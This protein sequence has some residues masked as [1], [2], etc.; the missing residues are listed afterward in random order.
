MKKWLLMLCLGCFATVFAADLDRSQPPTPGP[1]PK[2]ELG[3]YQSFTLDNGLKVFVVE[4]HKMPRVALSLTLDVDPVKEHDAVGYIS[5]TGQM[6]RSG[7]ESRDKDT[8]DREIDYIAANLF[9]TAGGVYAASLRR[10]CE[11]LFELTADVLINPSFPEEELAKLKKQAL[12]NLA[13]VANDPGQL[14]SRVRDALLFG[15]N[16][17]YGEIQEESDIE[18]IDRSKLADYHGKFF[19]PNVAYMAVVGDITFD[20]AK[21]MVT[22][23]FGGWEKKEVPSLKYPKPSL[24]ETRFVALV[25]RPES[26]Q[27]SLEVTNVVFRKLG[28]EDY[29]AATLAQT[30]LGGTS[31]YR[32]YNNLREDKGYTY[33][34]Y[35]ALGSDDV[36]SRFSTTAEVRNEVTAAS[37]KEM[38]YEIDRIRKEPV[39]ADELRLAKAYIGGNFAR[40]LESPQTIASFAINTAIYDLPADYYHGYL[41]RLEAVT[42]DDVKVAA[43]KFFQPEKSV[44]VAV[45]KASEIAESLQ[46]FGEVRYFDQNGDLY[47]PNSFTV[48]EGL[49]AQ[50]VVDKY[51][52]KLGGA[53]KVKAVASVKQVGKVDAMGQTMGVTMFRG[54]GKLLFSISS[55]GME[56]MKQVV[57]GEKVAM[58]QMGNAMPLDDETKARIKTMTTIFP[59]LNTEE[60][61]VKIKL[62]G[63][64]MINGKPAYKLLMNNGVGES[65]HFYDVESGLK[66]QQISK[67]STPM[68]EQETTIRYKE[69]KEAGG[70]LWPHEI[71]QDMGAFKLTLKFEDTQ[72]NGEA[73]E[74]ASLSE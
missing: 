46:E 73:P 18:N 3:K 41:Q 50:D 25:D 65:A 58:M 21:E 57:D 62:D 64:E 71:L 38:L 4:N 51:M 36:V 53:D 29:L 39:E 68:G 22:K 10:H 7:T 49:T 61:G 63:A 14:K 47:D 24:P 42:I 13:G 23:Y 34:S 70:V 9:T 6:L 72:V 17:P 56:V 60:T 33:G 66:I 67:Q 2:I 40:S 30:I 8:L 27:T 35:A 31:G 55:G 32:L 1:A 11:K 20:E 12:S 52:E 16:H 59:E 28:D 43:N 69:Y 15:K 48:P 54:E 45:G 19:R 37:V 44:I 74:G 5:M 26:V